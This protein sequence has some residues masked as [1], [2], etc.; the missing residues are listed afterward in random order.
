[1]LE[2]FLIA[3]LL[4]VVLWPVIYYSASSITSMGRQDISKLLYSIGEKTIFSALA[5]LAKGMYDM[6][7]MST[8]DKAYDPYY[9]GTTFFV[10]ALG[11]YLVK[12]SKKLSGD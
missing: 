10:F 1:M 8:S 7:M 9:I 12:K 5:I 3:Y 2:K 6:G 4:F 11:I